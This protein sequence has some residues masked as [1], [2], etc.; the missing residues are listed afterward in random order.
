MDKHQA[1]QKLKTSLSDW[2][3]IKQNVDGKTWEETLILYFEY[4]DDLTDNATYWVACEEEFLIE[5]NK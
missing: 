5:N 2:R 1:L 3:D 4:I